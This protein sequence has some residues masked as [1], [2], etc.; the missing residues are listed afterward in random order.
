MRM[1]SYYVLKTVISAKKII[2]EY[3]TFRLL[4]LPFFFFFLSSGM[5]MRSNVISYVTVN[6]SP[7]SDSSISSPYVADHLLNI[8]G[9]CG[10]FDVHGSRG[11]HLQNSSSRTI[12]VPPLKTQIHD[13]SLDNHL[14]GILSQF[15]IYT[16]I[17]VQL[18]VSK[19]DVQDSKLG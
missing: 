10:V 2:Y 6:D 17:K 7:D 5:K 8:N 13:C 15:S 14:S 9:V 16:P 4:M 3:F 11:S 12:I 19:E 1:C 18:S